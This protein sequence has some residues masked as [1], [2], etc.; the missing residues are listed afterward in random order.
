M[1]NEFRSLDERVR[2]LIDRGRPGVRGAPLEGNRASH[3]AGDTGDD[4]ER[5]A[6]TLQHRPL[7]DMDF[8]EGVGKLRESTAAHR[9]RLFGPE[10]DQAQLR[11]AKSVGGLDRC[12][13]TERAV[14]ASAVRHRVE[15]GATPDPSGAAVAEQIAGL[16][17]RDAE[18]GLL[19]PARGELVSG[20]LLG[21]V[22]ETR[23]CADR[24]EL[25]EPR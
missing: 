11:V 14:E 8:D 22:A 17:R 20:V 15:M 19:H 24:V 6:E 16:V 1:E 5:L 7:L 10:S 4:P 2:A 13:N 3:L 18:A 25:V 12:D 23:A 21:R 9:P